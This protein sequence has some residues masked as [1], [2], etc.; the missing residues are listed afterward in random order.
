MIIRP[1]VFTV[2]G[3]KVDTYVL[4]ML[5]KLG[6]SET[7][8][9]QQIFQDFFRGGKLLPLVIA[10]VPR[11]IFQYNFSHRGIVLARGLSQIWTPC[12]ICRLHVNELQVNDLDTEF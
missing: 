2:F 12:F 4:K 7:H 6:C 9:L 3:L 1:R 10:L 8:I 5:K 11:E